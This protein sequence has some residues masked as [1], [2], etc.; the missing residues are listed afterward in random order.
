[1]P[2]LRSAC[3]QTISSFERVCIW[4]RDLADSWCG[5]QADTY[6][7]GLVTS[8]KFVTFSILISKSGTTVK[9]LTFD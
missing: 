1:M 3:I 7:V 8:T 4:G 2:G 5:N 6:S 9:K